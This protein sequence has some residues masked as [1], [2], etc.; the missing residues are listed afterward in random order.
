MIEP[1]PNCFSIGGWR[2]RPRGCARSRRSL[3]AVGA[4]SWGRPLGLVHADRRRSSDCAG[5]REVTSSVV[6][7]LPRGLRFGLMTSTVWAVDRQRSGL[8]ACPSLA[9]G[10]SCFGRADSLDA[11]SLTSRRRISLRQRPGYRLGVLLDCRSSASR[12]T[13]H[14]SRVAEG[15]GGDWRRGWRP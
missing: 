4:P 9:F 13:G 5:D 7:V 15:P 1:R 6:S 2:R 14:F 12:R 10:S 11:W 8:W 3:L